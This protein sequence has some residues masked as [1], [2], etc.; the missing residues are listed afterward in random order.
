MTVRVARDPSP[1]RSGF[2]HGSLGVLTLATVLGA[3]GGL[4]H[5]LGDEDA[6]SPSFRVALFESD[7]DTAPDLNRRLPSDVALQGRV[8]ARADTASEAVG[9]AQPDLGVEYRD[10]ASL[11]LAA[12]TASQ[13]AQPTATGI[14][15]N[16]Q[17]VMPGQS[18]SQVLERTLNAAPVEAPEPLVKTV[19]EASVKTEGALAKYA[20]P[21]DNPDGKPTVSI[22]VGGLGINATRTRVAIEE[23]P[24]EVTLSFSPTA[25]NL[26][27]WVRRARAAGHEVVIELPMEAYDYGRARPHPSVL[28]ADLE[29][30][31]N[32]QRLRS[33]LSRASGYA[34][35][36]NFQGG[37]FATSEA[38]VRPVFDVLAERGLAFF[39][40]GSL[41]RSVFETTASRESLAFGR[42]NA[43]I[44][45]RP[46][47]DE[48]EKQLLTLEAEALEH[49][50]A[51]GTGMS[52][53]V[54]LDLLNDWIGRLESKGIVLAP[55]SYHA[56]RVS[57]SGQTLAGTLDPQG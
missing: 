8:M 14:R 24:P 48:I 18:L 15:I 54:T 21:F 30:D 53:P 1:V 36:M 51:L 35:V 47:A 56:K 9:T 26:A 45:A 38:A 40:D 43:W 28:R 16:G 33:L 50:A 11:Q 39:E 57:A 29:A 2:I 41:G 25:S 5:V 31:V 34:G 3:A 6:A 52:F 4:I 49:G 32:A 44:D 55:A 27:T 46:E 13:P 22:I 42:A 7:V 20:R 19:A 10:G 12:A 23:L 37:K 17:T